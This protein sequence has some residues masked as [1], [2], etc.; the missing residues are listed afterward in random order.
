[1]SDSLFGTELFGG[2]NKMM[3][4]EQD[5]PELAMALKMS[6]EEMHPAGGERDQAR[7]D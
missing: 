5:D 4:E 1:M 6:L 3:I 7:L 2:R